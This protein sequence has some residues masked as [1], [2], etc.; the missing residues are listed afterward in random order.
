MKKMLAV[1][2]LALGLGAAGTAQGAPSVVSRA[3]PDVDHGL[4]FPRNKQNEQSITR[5]PRNGWLVVGANDEFSL[6]PCIGTTDPLA[7]PCPFTCLKCL[8]RITCVR[9]ASVET[10]QEVYVELIILSL[11]RKI[12]SAQIKAGD[13]RA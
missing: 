5:D 10:H 3:V 6:E 2:C 8:R 1:V 11:G 7:S 12:R 13:F 9:P 4:Q